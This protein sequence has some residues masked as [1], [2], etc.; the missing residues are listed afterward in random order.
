MAQYDGIVAYD[1]DRLSRSYRDTPELRGWAD[2]NGKHLFIVSDGLHWPDADSG[3]IWAVKAEM[4]DAEWAKIRE[5]TMRAQASLR[6]AGYLVGS[7][8]LGYHIVPDGPHKRLSPSREGRDF[9]PWLFAAYAGGESLR[10]LCRRTGGHWSGKV[11]S[12]IL[13]NPV[14][15][16][17]R[18][19]G[20]ECE[21]R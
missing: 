12:D 9:I 1:V 8:P 18:I 11:L 10:G 7:A 4:A 21:P 16:G 13:H 3:V 20:H 19:D 14:Y 15:R 17:K 6:A 2:D 5:R